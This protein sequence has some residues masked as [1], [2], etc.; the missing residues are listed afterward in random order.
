MKGG[1]GGGTGADFAWALMQQQGWK[2]GDGL[3]A[4]KQGMK[5]AI[6][7][8]LK[9]DHSGMGHNRKEEFEFH[10]WDHVFNSA[11]KGIS[12]DESKGEVTVEFK[13]DKS[14]VSTKKLRRK[15]QKEIRSKLYS[16]F[17][18]AATLRGGD[19]VEEKHEECLVEEVKDMS[20]TLSDDELVKACGGRTA[21]KGARHGQRMTGK[22]QRVADAEKLYLE[23]LLQRN[24]E[25]EAAKKAGKNGGKNPGKEVKDAAVT[26]SRDAVERCKDASDA[27]D[28]VSKKK[29]K[30]S[31][32]KDMAEVEEGD[33]QIKKKKK[34]RK[35]ENSEV[36]NQSMNGER[37]NQSILDPTVVEAPS[38][39][40]CTEQPVKKKK[41]KRLP[42][43]EEMAVPEATE[44][45]PRKKK[46]KRRKESASG[47]CDSMP[48][49]ICSTDHHSGAEESLPK[50]KK[51]KKGS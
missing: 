24:R 19:L 25:K 30:K 41:K 29:K 13:T 31:K 51:S 17:V 35:R 1:G 6:K 11:A 48:S 12:V 46:K 8:K 22:L 21:H 40:E 5:D 26:E 43:P 14:E 7:P 49:D 2:Q 34:K 37:E 36:E 32:H 39:E 33:V 38:P 16:H 27:T 44:S 50:R 45:E 23:Q 28:P 15:M 20:R 47:V 3:G 42:L 4:R 9:F 10:W 18:K